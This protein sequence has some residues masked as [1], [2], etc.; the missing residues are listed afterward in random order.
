VTDPAQVRDLAAAAL[1]RHQRIDGLVN[2]AGVSM[3]GPLDQVDGL[4][5]SFLQ[6]AEILR[7]RLGPLGAR[8]SVQEAPGEDPPPLVIHNDRARTELGWRPRPL[9]T[10][11]V[12][13]AESLRDLGLLEE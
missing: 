10:T 2:N 11:I 6:L 4:T 1:D 12:E 8:V 9:E 7:Q 3:H 13:S 5:I